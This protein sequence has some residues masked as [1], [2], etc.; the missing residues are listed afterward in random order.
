MNNLVSFILKLSAIIAVLVTCSCF[1]ITRPTTEFSGFG[2]S[3]EIKQYLS[4]KSDPDILKN[5]VQVLSNKL[6]PRDYLSTDNLDACATYI[7]E[8]MS[9][10]GGIVSNQTYVVDN[11]EYKNVIGK[12]GPVSNDIIV[13]GAH[14]DAHDKLPG[15]D[16][17]ASGVAG[18]LDLARLLGKSSGT[19]SKSIEL[20]AFTLEEPPYFATSNM[21]SAVYSKKLKESGINVVIMI[22]LEMIGYFTEVE[23][24]QK[25]PAP[26]LGLFYPNKGNFIA[27]VDQ[28]FSFHAQK[29]RDHINSMGE[30]EA[31]SINAPAILP[32]IDFS[33]H[34]NFWQY[35]YPAIMVTDTAFYR[36]TAYH[37]EHDTEDRLDYIKMSAVINGVFSYLQNL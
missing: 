15:A 21:G 22:S 6:S 18:L 24:S 13:V 30:I 2:K 5:H 25:F 3:N 36:N 12:F 26:L 11:R 7:S 27:V 14:Y 4:T 31:Y 29:L 1:I 9:S 35:N 23:D 10:S 19:L 8:A 16:D 37:K 17:N 28:L 32:G 34:R 20:V 33:D